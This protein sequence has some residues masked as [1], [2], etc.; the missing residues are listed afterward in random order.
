MCP[1]SPA[2]PLPDPTA[3]RLRLSGDPTLPRVNT[4]PRGNTAPA[5][6]FVHAQFAQA[7]PTPRPPELAPADP[8]RVFALRAAAAITPSSGGVLPPERRQRLN[9]DAA[10]LGLRPFDAALIIAIVQDA[11][12]TG[13]DPLGGH[14]ADQLALIRPVPARRPSSAD[15]LMLMVATVAVLLAFAAIALR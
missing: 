14:T 8:R 1:V 15:T 12:R 7:L 5:S 4:L 11:A 3:P 9:K 10:A 2:M 6:P 13:R